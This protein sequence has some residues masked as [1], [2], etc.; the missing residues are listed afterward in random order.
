MVAGVTPHVYALVATWLDLLQMLANFI[1]HS[2][3]FAR[4]VLVGVVVGRKV[5]RTEG[6]ALLT[7]VAIRT[8]DAERSAEADHH[9]P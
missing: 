7:L 1:E 4:A 3:H 5:V 8:A 9:R 6:L 2:Q